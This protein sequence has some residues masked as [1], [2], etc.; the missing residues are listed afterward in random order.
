[1][2]SAAL[3]NQIKYICFRKHH[4]QEYANQIF[5]ESRQTRPHFWFLELRQIASFLNFPESCKFPGKP[6]LS[7]FPSQ[8]QYEQKSIEYYRMTINLGCM[9]EAVRP[10]CGC[11]RAPPL[12]PNRK[13]KRISTQPN[14]DI[15]NWK[16]NEKQAS[17]CYRSFPSGSSSRLSGVWPTCRSTSRLAAPVS[18]PHF[19]L[20]KPT[21]TSLF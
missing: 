11:A 19:Y 5:R 18:R 21:G 6:K 17:D 20:T 4:F 12:Q 2:A 13:E 7:T 14:M 10:Q 1:M 9:N 15:R 3:A 8:F 16:R